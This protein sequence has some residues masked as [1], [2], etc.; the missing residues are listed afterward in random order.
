M[1][2]TDLNICCF[3]VIVSL[4]HSDVTL[5]STAYSLLYELS[6]IYS[7]PINDLCIEPACIAI[8]SNCTRFATSLSRTMMNAEPTL[9]VDILNGALDAL[10]R[11][12]ALAPALLHC[13]RSWW[14]ALL[15]IAERERASTLHVIMN[16][17]VR[18]TL[19]DVALRPWLIVHVWP[20]IGTLPSLVD[21]AISCI[22]ESMRSG[23][24]SESVSDVF[25][26]MS[27][28]SKLVGACVLNR[29]LMVT[30]ERDYCFR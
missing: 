2:F 18:C 16:K 8:P 13:L 14:P 28:G 30:V 4:C 1:L 5:R 17:L 19:L 27:D 26:A 24:A 25:V 23:R 11:N 9:V 7:L 12:S 15:Q 10:D 21:V 6:S 22:I 29:L 20:I 3:Q